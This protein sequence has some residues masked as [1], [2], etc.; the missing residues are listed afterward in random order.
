ML[1]NLGAVG[2]FA[3][4][5]LAYFALFYNPDLINRAFPLTLPEE[6][7]VGKVGETLVNSGL[8]LRVESVERVASRDFANLSVSSRSSPGRTTDYVIVRLRVHNTAESEQTLR[9]Y[10]SQQDI[11]FL[12]GAR[13]PMPDVMLASF[14]RDAKAITGE[15]AL[16]SKRLNPNER[17]SGVL[18]FPTNQG[19]KD[20]SLLVVPNRYRKVPE[21]TASFEIDLTP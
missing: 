15:A 7:V 1:A 19:A 16:P 21:K 5:A 8:E 12:L 13:Q 20:L 6:R 18:V 17:A 14:P 3:L 11:E 2:V 4:V 10:G 9:Y